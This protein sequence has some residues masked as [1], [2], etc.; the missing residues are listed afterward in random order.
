M[1]D[2]TDTLTAPP[3]T[4]PQRFLKL[5]GPPL[6][7]LATGLIMTALAERESTTIAWIYG[8][9]ISGFSAFVCALIAFR[10]HRQIEVSAAIREELL[11]LNLQFN[12][13][14]TEK[15]ILRQALED[16]EQRSRDL[17]S[18]SG[19][20]VFELDE[21]GKAGFVSAAVS[22]LLGLEPIELAGVAVDSLISE[23]DRNGFHETLN[24][25]RVERQLQ[26]T[27]LHLMDVDQHLIPTTL[28][29]LV[30]HDT[31]H[32]FS[33]FRLSMQPPASL[34]WARIF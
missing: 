32:G 16:S 33:G 34:R 5:F 28:R 29:V 2:H 6:C 31:L 25:A 30:L 26:R 7:V 12:N 4:A 15:R 17:V 11:A 8:A 13:A 18:L 1:D 21:H 9:L 22:E 24:T 27:E 20:I 10:W 19:G 14:Q 3:E 23:P